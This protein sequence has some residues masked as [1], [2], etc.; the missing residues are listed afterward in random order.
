MNRSIFVRTCARRMFV[1]VAIGIATS[2]THGFL[3]TA[4]LA[5]NAPAQPIEHSN[6]D[7]E[8][9]EIETPVKITPRP[10]TAHDP[11]KGRRSRRAGGHLGAVASAKFFAEHQMVIA[12]VNHANQLYLATLGDYPKSHEEFM[13]KIIKLNGILLPE[14]EPDHE[15]IYVPEQPEVGLQIRL[16]QSELKETTDAQQAIAASSEMMPVHNGCELVS[17]F[18]GVTPACQTQRTSRRF[19]L[20]CRPTPQR[21]AICNNQVAR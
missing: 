19:K 9:P 8:I 13:D 5:Q 12:N 14:L 17:C 1:A 2:F 15:Y 21:H 16:K 10:F 4:V 18:D 6:S 11:I 3:Q 20:R 7:N